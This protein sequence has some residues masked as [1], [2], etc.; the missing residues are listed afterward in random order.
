MRM[1]YTDPNWWVVILSALATVLAAAAF[2]YSWKQ[3]NL[4]TSPRLRLEGVKVE[5]LENGSCPV[6][7]VTLVNDGNA[8]ATD[9]EVYIRVEGERQSR[10]L[11]PQVE[12]TSDDS[13]SGQ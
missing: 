3:L 9:V 10:Y 7:F 11:W 12:Q 4:A 5:G 13:H 1:W 2:W 6:F 8:P